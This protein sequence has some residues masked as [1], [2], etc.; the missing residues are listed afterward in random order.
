VAMHSSV[1]VRYPFL[2][3]E[4]FAFLARLDPKWKLR[5]FRD[6]HL[7]RLLA[8][9]WL[10]ASV[11]KRRKVIFRAP[12]DSFHMDPEPAFVSQLLSEESLHRTGYFDPAAVHHWRRAFRLMPAGSLPRLSV[13]A[14]L[15]A[16]VA[17]QLWHHLYIDAKLADLPE[18]V[19]GVS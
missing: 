16:V 12:L 7:L 14:G 15:A 17:T 6:K 13:E 1:E 3:E 8:E 9:R 10:P 4:V 11:Y 19:S 18:S 5:G 2:D